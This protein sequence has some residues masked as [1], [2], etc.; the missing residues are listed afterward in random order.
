MEDYFKFFLYGLAQTTSFQDHTASHSTGT[1]VLHLSK[2]AVPRYEFARPGEELLRKYQKFV[3]PV[4]SEIADR[5]E[6]NN[7]LENLR[8]TLLPKLISGELRIEDAERM[9]GDVR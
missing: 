2:N 6:Q 1:T 3:E 8:D 5:T 7:V 9:V 4:F